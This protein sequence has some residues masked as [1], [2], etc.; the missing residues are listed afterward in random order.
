MTILYI[1]A[2]LTLSALLA[3]SPAIRC[4]ARESERDRFVIGGGL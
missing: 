3:A 1:A 2:Y 4:P